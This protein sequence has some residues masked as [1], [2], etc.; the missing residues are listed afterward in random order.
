MNETERKWLERG[1]REAVLDGDE[2]AWTALYESCFERLY[3]HV[4]YRVDRDRHRAEEI[5][6]DAWLIAVRR[7]RH[8]DPERG[9][10]EY[11][12][13]G[14]AENVLRNQRRRWWRRERTEV[15]VEQDASGLVPQEALATTE[16]V[17]MAMAVIPPQYQ[18]V[19]RAKYEER[20][21]V[22]EIAARNNASPKAVESLLSRARAAFR[23]A[24]M[25]LEKER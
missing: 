1:L 9:A 22:T 3:A 19:L 20:L 24:Y 7:I 6:Q 25:N 12:M 4:Y 8:F 11:W 23:E 5:I 16:Q 18:G 2:R 10:F 13:R 17:A 14:I 21:P 15:A